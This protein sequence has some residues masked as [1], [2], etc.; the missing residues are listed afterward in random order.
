[1]PTLEQ[2]Q[3]PDGLVKLLTWNVWGGGEDWA[4]RRDLLAA[5]LSQQAP[6]LAVAQEVGVV[7]DGAQ[8]AP[9]AGAM[10]HPHHATVA[11]DE[12]C[13]GLAISSRF[14]I[15]DVTTI[16]LP[17]S[18]EERQPRSALRALVETGGVPILL[19]TTHLSWQLD[20]SLLRQAQLRHLLDD[21]DAWTTAHDDPVLPIIAGD[22]N[23]EPDADEIRALL[24]RAAPLRDGIVFH[25][26]ARFDAGN[27]CTWTNDN[28]YAALEREPD[29]RIDYILVR[30]APSH[31]GRVTRSSVVRSEHGWASDHHGVVATIDTSI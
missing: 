28:P 9:L 14:P 13:T 10:G 29:G 23:A 26:T 12:G 1:M 27:P 24:G 25:D 16:H 17:S 8:W 7:D 21:M 22:L 20:Q 18:D 19:Y 2:G 5:T 6:D 4:S 3:P 31:R 15:H 30:W 11:A